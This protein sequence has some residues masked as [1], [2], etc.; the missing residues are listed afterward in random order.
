[1][2]T[3]TYECDHQEQST[4][5][6]KSKGIIHGI[7]YSYIPFIL[8]ESPPALSAPP[9]N[10]YAFSPLCNSYLF[11]LIGNSYLFLLSGS[12]YVFSH[13]RSLGEPGSILAPS[14]DS[15]GLSTTGF[16]GT[17]LR[18]LRRL[19]IMNAPTRRVTVPS[20]DTT[21]PMAICAVVERP[22]PPEE[23]GAGLDEV[24]WL[25]LAREE[26]VALEVEEEEAIGDVADALIMQ[27]YQW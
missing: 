6:P 24:V 4:S 22:P 8:L 15:S 25:V 11:P 2:Q 1:M 13:C 14:P 9:G 17:I 12:S 21:T 7:G 19:R 18:F 16:S 23:D 20:M 27:M 26:V 5:T 10:S 3:V